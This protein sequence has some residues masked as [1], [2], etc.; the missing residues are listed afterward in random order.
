MGA[1]AGRKFLRKRLAFFCTLRYDSSIGKNVLRKANLM[2]KSE[3]TALLRSVENSARKMAELVEAGD[4]SEAGELAFEF[5][6]DAEA[7]AEE[8]GL[9]Q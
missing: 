6:T 5:V 1:E 4:V 9:G 7:V 8:F 2:S 3:L